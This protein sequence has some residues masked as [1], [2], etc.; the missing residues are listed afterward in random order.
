MQI[1]PTK[2]CIVQS[3]TDS[4]KDTKNIAFCNP[5]ELK[6]VI[7]RGMMAIAELLTSL[8]ALWRNIDPDIVNLVN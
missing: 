7:R 5:I 8:D 1:M 2:A 4:F 6:A 3:K